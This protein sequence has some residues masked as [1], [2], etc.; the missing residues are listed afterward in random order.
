MTSR[1][2]PPRTEDPREIAA[3]RRSQDDDNFDKANKVVGGTA[4]N[5]AILAAD[6]DI[7]DGGVSIF[8]VAIEDEVNSMAFFLARNY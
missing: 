4:N 5:I 6:G 2:R 7:K 8:D 3:W 1:K